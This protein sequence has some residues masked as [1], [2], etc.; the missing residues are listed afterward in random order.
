MISLILLAGGTGSRMK[1]PLPKQFHLLQE[2]PVALHSFELFASDTRLE[3]IIV[4]SDPAFHS[5]F[6]APHVRFALP[7]QRRQDSMQN[8]LK[9]AKYPYICVHDAARPLLHTNDFSAL[10]KA[11]IE[12]GA[13]TL[14]TP[15][16]FT[17]KEADIAGF[18]KNTLDRSK[19]WQI[20]TPQFAKRSLLEEGFAIAKAENRTVTDDVGLV[21]LTGHP[22]KLVPAQFPNPKLT[23]P[24]DW[25]F[26]NTL[27]CQSINC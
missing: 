20:L 3:E 2:K 8:G 11:G 16:K 7:G 9:A 25:A 5:L 1:H 24:E 26:L 19:L 4:V 14:A 17:I 22:V 15:M 21:E 18:V 23:T 12:Y 27:L 13:A 6:S 10:L